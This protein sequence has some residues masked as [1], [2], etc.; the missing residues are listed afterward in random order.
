MQNSMSTDI[1]LIEQLL[2]ASFPGANQRGQSPMFTN[3]TLCSA[4]QKLSE[5]QPGMRKHFRDR[6]R[7]IDVDTNF[8]EWRKQNFKFVDGIKLRQLVPADINTIGKTIEE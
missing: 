7:V 1:I 6:R 4:W 2:L 3:P 5:R 8:H